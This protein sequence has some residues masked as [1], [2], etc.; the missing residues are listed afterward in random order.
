MTKWQ[1]ISLSEVIQLDLNKEK[2]DSEKRY[3]MV[4]V[5]SFGKGLF[6]RPPLENGNTSYKFMLRLNSDHIVMS[7][8]FGWEGALALSSKEFEG[9]YVS[10]NFPTF[11]CDSSR[12]DRRFLGW[13]MQ[14]PSFWRE[15]GQRAKGMG[16]RRKTLTP[17]SL[18][19]SQ[20]PLPPMREQKSIVSKL[21]ELQDRTVQ[22][23]AHL[24]AIEAD[25]S[26]L[27]RSYLF[28]DLARTYQKRK[29][30]ELMKLRSPDVLVNHL[31]RY[32]FAG[33][34]S[35]GRGV[36]ASANK[37]G[38]DFSYG[39]LSTV[40]EGDFTFPKLM[41]WEGALGVVPKECDGMVVSPEF[42]VFT[43]DKDMVLPEILDIYFRSP[44][45]WPELASLSGGTNVRRRRIQPSRFL[46]YEISLPP[47]EIQKKV[48]KLHE[49]ALMLKA[50]HKAIHEANS[51][52]LPA[53]LELLFANTRRVQ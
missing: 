12:L 44:S 40:R 43:V 6:R 16:D 46:D 27:V 45:V 15:L 26:A 3:D 37:A 2:I 4:G 9:S 38:S 20:I 36:F 34:Y 28:G 24:V 21:D 47:L 1:N 18:L 41:A 51:S 53:T 14:Q 11:I 32:Q 10:P 48:R 13:L 35:F 29:M 25:A 49:Y 17:D 8:L 30:K 50:R 42:P 22:L 5:L 31:Q 23:T 7:Q 52:I 33:V 19:K 39:R